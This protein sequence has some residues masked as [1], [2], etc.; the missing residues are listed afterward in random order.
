MNQRQI[1]LKNLP[2]PFCGGHSSQIKQHVALGISSF[3]VCCKN[4]GAEGPT[5][6]SE[7][8]ASSHWSERKLRCDFCREKPLTQSE[9]DHMGSIQH[10]SLINQP[11][12]NDGGKNPA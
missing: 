7:R 12:E 8:Q 5:G 1:I 11:V 9:R 10:N 2:C 4:C 3:S 6:T